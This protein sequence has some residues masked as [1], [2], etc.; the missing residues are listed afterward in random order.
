MKNAVSEWYVEFLK[1][2]NESLFELILA[3]NF[4]DIGPLL[5]LT[6]CAVAM[7]ISDKRTP[8]AI[9]AHFGINREYKDPD[10]ER[11]KRLY[12][13]SNEYGNPTTDKK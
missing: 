9:A 3:A 13:W 7:Q 2:E 1:M 5:E 6:C 4:M 12:P 8:Q 11:I 10:P